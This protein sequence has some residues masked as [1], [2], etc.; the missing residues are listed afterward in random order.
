[1]GFTAMTRP[2]SRGPSRGTLATLNSRDFHVVR[3]AHT[4][5]FTLLP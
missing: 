3:P 2:T 4:D 1:M 5:A